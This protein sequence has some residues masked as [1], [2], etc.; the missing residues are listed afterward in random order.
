[1]A[2]KGKIE[3]KKPKKR[4]TW[5]I[6]PVTRIKQS[7]KLY[8]RKGKKRFDPKKEM[9]CEVESSSKDYRYCPKCSAELSEKKVDHKKRKACPV[10]GFVFYKNPAPASGVIITQ[11]H[12]I[13]LV[14]RKYNPFKGDWSLPAGFIEYDESPEK[15]AIREIKEEVNL[16][17]RIKKLFN[18]YS[19][20]D[21]PRTKAVLI[22]Y[23]GEVIGGILKPGDDA[24]EAR[25]FG[26]DEIPP[27]IAFQAHRQLIKD[28]FD[29]IR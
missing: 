18:V 22:V 13:L 21:D 29:S 25:F 15:C 14:K 5:K 9:E 23:L 10:C 20:S 8:Q 19:G 28:Y 26:K 7:N 27:N 11:D 16:D 4:Q 24:E 6:S 17:I 1:M 3:I 2:E 12:K